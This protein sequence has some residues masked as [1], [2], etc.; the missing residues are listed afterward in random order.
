MYGYHHWIPS[1]FLSGLPI[2]SSNG[3]PTHRFH[4]LFLT[5]VNVTLGSKPLGTTGNSQNPSPVGVPAE[6]SSF[7]QIGRSRPRSAGLLPGWGS[8]TVYLDHAGSPISRRLSFWPGLSPP[9]EGSFL[10]YPVILAARGHLSPDCPP[11]RWPGSPPYRWWRY[12]STLIMLKELSNASRKALSQAFAVNG[13]I[14]CEKANIV[15]HVGMDHARNSLAMKSYAYKA[16]PLWAFYFHRHF[17]AEP[18]RWS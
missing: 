4:H 8:S 7:G 17:L 11:D 2:T 1:Q 5:Q 13:S 14:Y 3:N 16:C 12:P 9:L 18:D 6:H 10:E 15:S